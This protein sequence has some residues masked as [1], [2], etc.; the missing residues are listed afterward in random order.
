MSVG[1][2]EAFKEAKRRKKEE[3][4]RRKHQSN[5]NR[6]RDHNELRRR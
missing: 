1:Q 6:P 3:E 5:P 2:R 4:E